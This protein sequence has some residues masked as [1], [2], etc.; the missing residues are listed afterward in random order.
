[1]QVRSLFLLFL[2]TS[3]IAGIVQE[4]LVFPRIDLQAVKE[5]RERIAYQVRKRKIIKGTLIGA[6]GVITTVCLLDWLKGDKY[7]EIGLP[8]NLKKSSDMEQAVWLVPKLLTRLDK[9]TY[10]LPESTGLDYAKEWVVDWKSI[11]QSFQ[12]A[13]MLY[14]ANAITPS[15]LRSLGLDD[16]AA[17]FC[18]PSVYDNFQLYMEKVLKLPL[19][20]AT[21]AYYAWKLDE[22]HDIAIYDFRSACGHLKPKIERL[23]GFLEYRLGLM[24]SPLGKQELKGIIY[25]IGHM[26]DSLFEQAE[27]VGANLETQGKDLKS[28]IQSYRLDLQNLMD[29]VSLLEHDQA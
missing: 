17:V 2:F 13:V 11:K 3:N 18:P 22:N 7:I 10:Y 28:T 23:L 14:A 19:M 20:Q 29:H 27:G 1:M 12:I 4:K 25:K 9:N 24:K 26:T 5:H 21:L 15:I 8:E 16:E 6:C